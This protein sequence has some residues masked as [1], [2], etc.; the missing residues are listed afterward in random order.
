MALASE[1]VFAAALV[2]VA[3]SFGALLRGRASDRVLLTLT[4]VLA[5]IAVIAAGALGVNLVEGFT[6]TEALLLAAGGVGAAAVAEASLLGL[7]RGLHRL[8]EIERVGDAARA[9]P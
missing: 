3:I 1:I 2:V 4:I 5:A 6:S 7:A 9:E 8:R